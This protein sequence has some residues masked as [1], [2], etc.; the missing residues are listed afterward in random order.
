METWLP[1]VRTVVVF[2]ALMAAMAVGVIFRGRALKG[3]CG[4]TGADCYCDRNGLPRACEAVGGQIPGECADPKH[5][6]GDG[7]ARLVG[8]ELVI[9]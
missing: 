7:H 4:G 5:Q 8:Q 3:S 9:K 1:V 6:H 2:A